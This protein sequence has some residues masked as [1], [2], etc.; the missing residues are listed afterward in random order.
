M[1]ELADKDCKTVALSMFKHVKLLLILEFRRNGIPLYM[2]SML[3]LLLLSLMILRFTPALQ[4]PIVSFFLL[5]N[6]T[7]WCRCTTV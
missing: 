6:S 3:G 5:L 2:S 1:I 4:V 7:L